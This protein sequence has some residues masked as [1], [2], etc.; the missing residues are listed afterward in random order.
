M[1]LPSRMTMRLIAAGAFVLIATAM[2][3]PLGPKL[4]ALH[5]SMVGLV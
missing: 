1:Y 3:S 5:A 4:A 2:H